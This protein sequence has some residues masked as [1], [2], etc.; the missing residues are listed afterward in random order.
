[1]SRVIP[2]YSVILTDLTVKFTVIYMSTAE[3]I[4]RTLKVCLPCPMLVM[5]SDSGNDQR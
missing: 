5:P 1:M 3:V 4:C 2:K